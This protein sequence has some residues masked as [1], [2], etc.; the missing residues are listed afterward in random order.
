[1]NYVYNGYQ[2]I[3]A[4]PQTTTMDPMFNQDLQAPQC[5]MQ[6]IP[7]W[8]GPD[9]FP[10]QRTNPGTTSKYTIAADGDISIMPFPAI[11][12][13]QNNVEVSGD[14]IMMLVDRPET[15]ALLEWLAIP[16][17]IQAWVKSPSGA[18][19]ANNKVPSEWYASNYKLQVAASIFT[20]ASAAGFDAS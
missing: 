7:F 6:K 17:G 15:R 9:L 20:N 12:P 2:G 11:D 3:V 1:P 14:T 4:Q 19:S 18:I 16:E 13:A 5:W 8:Y 10:D